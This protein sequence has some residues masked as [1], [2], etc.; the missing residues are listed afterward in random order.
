MQ[1]RSKLLL[2][3]A[4]MLVAGTAAASAQGYEWNG[5]RAGWDRPA[6]VYEVAPGP[7]Y[8]PYGAGPY[9]ALNGT[10]HPTPSSTQGDVGPEGNNNGTRTGIYRSW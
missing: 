7:V 10:N 4:A 1:N 6:P 3:V 5:P 8:S 2:S 9:G